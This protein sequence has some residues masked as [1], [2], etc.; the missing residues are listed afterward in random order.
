MPTPRPSG[1]A[2]LFVLAIVSAVV[3]LYVFAW[4][5]RGGIVGAGL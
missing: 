3:V 4:V 2:V 1:D 5:F